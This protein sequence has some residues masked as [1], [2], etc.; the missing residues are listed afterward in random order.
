MKIG[1]AGCT[2][3]M[4][5]ALMRKASELG[6]DV[7]A[8][9]VR[10]ERTIPDA[11]Y[12]SAHGIAASDFLAVADPAKLAEA[13]DVVIDFT[14]PA[15]TLALAEAAAR[16]GT[17][18]VIGTTGMSLQDYQKLESFSA[19]V[20]MVVAANMSMGVTVL[21][22]LVQQAAAALGDDFDIE[23]VE[24]HHR[25][26]VDAPSGTALMLGRSA[27]DGRGV[28]LEHE[29]IYTR[30]GHTGARPAGAIGFATLRGGD[31]VG[32]HSVIL[33]GAG[34]RIELSHRA[35]NRDIFATG[36]LRAAT[37]VAKQP[38]GLYTMKHVLGMAANF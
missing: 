15:H 4:G 17:A 10:A 26:K 12:W 3:R 28:S 31:V 20:P 1:I 2:G 21:S 33:A 6:L 22:E 19:Q 34:E 16:R 32:E 14:S 11:S 27:A 8:G 35:T 23:I 5:M 13:S 37:W 7:A 9:S 29:A 30:E 38:A 18:L 24:M 25:H 36:A